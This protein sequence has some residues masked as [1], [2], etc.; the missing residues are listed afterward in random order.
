MRE[1]A[2][3]GSGIPGSPT[4]APAQQDPEWEWGV[5][6]APGA[7]SQAFGGAVCWPPSPSSPSRPP[8]AQGAPGWPRCTCQGRGRMCTHFNKDLASSQQNGG[9]PGPGSPGG[10]HTSRGGA[11]A[12]NRPRPRALPG[13]PLSR[14]PKHAAPFLSARPQDRL[15]LEP[16]GQAPGPR[17]FRP[18]TPPPWRALGREGGDCTP[19]AGPPRSGG[20]AGSASD[21]PQN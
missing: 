7:P 2:A 12:G 10:P 13:A 3:R 19:Q 14:A 6:R 16:A 9:G 17:S 18:E 21:T 1:A 20:C 4:G 5:C 11:G 8:K 15:W